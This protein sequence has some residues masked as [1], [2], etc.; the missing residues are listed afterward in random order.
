[1]AEMTNKFAM[2]LLLQKIFRLQKL[3][4]EASN[5]FVNYASDILQICE[6]QGTLGISEYSASRRLSRMSKA[7]NWKFPV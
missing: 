4:Q 1:M 5:W 3:A 2:L 6:L 7:A